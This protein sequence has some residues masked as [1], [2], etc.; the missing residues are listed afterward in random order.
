MKTTNG[1]QLGFL[2]LDKS[3]LLGTF[4][5]L[6][7]QNFKQHLGYDGWSTP[8]EFRQEEGRYM[9]R[10]SKVGQSWMLKPCSLAKCKRQMKHKWEEISSGAA[11]WQ[12]TGKVDKRR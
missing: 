4:Q 7:I 2:G 6:V 11:A 8:S 9:L 5:T 1:L 12:S 3:R 10:S